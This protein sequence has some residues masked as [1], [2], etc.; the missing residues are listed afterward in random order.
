[1]SIFDLEQEVINQYY[2]DINIFW[3]NV[4]DDADTVCEQLENAKTD[5]DLHRIIDNTYRRYSYEP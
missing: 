5:D 4:G 3:E 2:C 1:M